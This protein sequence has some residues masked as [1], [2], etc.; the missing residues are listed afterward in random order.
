M[1]A[2]DHLA[3][4]ALDLKAVADDGTFVGYASTWTLDQGRDQ[5]V[6]GA[7]A[8]SLAERPAQRVKMLRDHMREQV[9]GVWT[10]LAE[11]V[12]GLKATGRLILDTVLGRETHALMKAGA[13]DGLS[14]GFRV[15]RD[16]FDRQKG[17][18]FLDEVDLREI[19]VTAFPMN[20][21]AV[22]T[23]VKRHE[24]ARA[25]RIAAAIVRAARAI[26]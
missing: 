24:E 23:A 18:R 17:I 13:L 14:I 5:I 8:K 15:K 3:P 19:S 16:R 11:D 25:A 1:T 26:R 20:E 10:S 2:L 6:R 7:F 4:L 21:A 12:R 9:I 22:V